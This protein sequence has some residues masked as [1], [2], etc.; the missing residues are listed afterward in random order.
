MIRDKCQLQKIR[1]SCKL[2]E[3]LVIPQGDWE[4]LLLAFLNVILNS[5]EAIKEGGVISI[6]TSQTDEFIKVFDSG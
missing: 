3:G 4:Q 1:I 6:T 5:I 2:E